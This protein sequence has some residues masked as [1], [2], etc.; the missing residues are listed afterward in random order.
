MVIWGFLSLLQRLT[1]DIQIYHMKM[2]DSLLQQNTK[3]FEECC[4]ILS[5]FKDMSS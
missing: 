1:T 3:Q 4:S 2:G 5:N